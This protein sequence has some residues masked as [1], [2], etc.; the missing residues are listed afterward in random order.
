M[1]GGERAG[2]GTYP[3]QAAGA[4][5]LVDVHEVGHHAALEQTALCL[6]ADLRRGD[7]YKTL[8]LPSS[9]QVRQQM[10]SMHGVD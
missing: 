4:L 2:E 3:P 9:L 1:E 6:H 7:L 8:S 5:C 10:F